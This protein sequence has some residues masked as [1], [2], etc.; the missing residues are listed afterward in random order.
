[1]K[2]L[3]RNR[4]DQLVRELETDAYRLAH[5]LAPD[6][7]AAERIILEAFGSLAPSLGATPQIVELKERLHARV[8]E[9]ASRGR[10]AAVPIDRPEQR[11]IVSE[12]L[13]LRIVDLLEE[14]QAVEPVGRRRTL[15]L[16]LGG[17]VLLGGLAAFL[18]IRAN[19]LAVA[20]PEVTDLS[21]PA[22]AK[23]CPCEE[24]SRSRSVDIR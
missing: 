10:Q 11:V 12:N 20:K 19:A 6:P 9:R 3:E 14:E 22:G 13:H 8:R 15:L 5:A 4:I 17:L 24:T 18:S 2:T 23:R 21:P 16:G 7:A 1:M